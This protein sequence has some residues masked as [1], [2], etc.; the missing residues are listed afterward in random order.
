QP[1]ERKAQLKLISSGD[2]ILFI[3]ARQ[4]SRLGSKVRKAAVGLLHLSSVTSE[5]R[6]EGISKRG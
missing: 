3:K 4:C 2:Y 5:Q 1:L 6:H